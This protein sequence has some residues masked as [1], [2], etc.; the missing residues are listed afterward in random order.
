MEGYNDE[1]KL[2]YAQFFFLFSLDARI[3]IGA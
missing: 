2:F 3:W 1:Y